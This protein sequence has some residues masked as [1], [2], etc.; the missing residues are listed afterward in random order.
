MG[1]TTL[2]FVDP[3]VKVVLPRDLLSQQMLPAI[4]F[5]AGD[6]TMSQQDDAPVHRGCPTNSDN[7]TRDLGLHHS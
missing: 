6:T 5:V 7:A 1:V 4:K 3:G 2:F